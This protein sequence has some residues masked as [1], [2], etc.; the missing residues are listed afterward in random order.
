[1]KPRK[2]TSS[3]AF[4]AR[5]AGVGI[6]PSALCAHGDPAFVLDLVGSWKKPTGRSDDNVT[7]MLPRCVAAQLIGALTAA[8]THTDGEQAARIFQAQADAAL[9]AV[10]PQFNQ[11]PGYGS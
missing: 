8:V 9:E 10:L 7:V 6:N 3:G 1:M 5:N 11:L 4:Y 2:I